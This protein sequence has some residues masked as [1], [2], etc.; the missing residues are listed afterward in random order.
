MQPVEGRRGGEPG[1]LKFRRNIIK[2]S[3]G[4]FPEKFVLSY[5]TT[6]LYTPESSAL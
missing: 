2:N 4:I 5:N 6:R 3:G 1:L